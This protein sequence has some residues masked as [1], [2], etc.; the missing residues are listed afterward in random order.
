MPFTGVNPGKSLVIRMTVALAMGAIFASTAWGA[1]V[2]AQSK[3]GARSHDETPGATTPEDAPT[4]GEGEPAEPPTARARLEFKQGPTLWPEGNS[5]F[6]LINDMRRI[7]SAAF[8]DEHFSKRVFL[9][10]NW[11]GAR[12]ET[13]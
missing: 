11:G 10:G 9:T 1:G 3:R 4:P 7:P 12:T 5:P 13:L 2:P 8:D 6:G